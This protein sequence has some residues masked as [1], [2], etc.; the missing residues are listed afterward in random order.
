MLESDSHSTSNAAHP[1]SSLAV[2]S[3]AEPQADSSFVVGAVIVAVFVLGVVIAVVGWPLFVRILLWGIVLACGIAAGL[4]VILA[5]NSEVQNDLKTGYWITSAVFA[6]V[7]FG[8]W[9]MV[10]TGPPQSFKSTAVPPHPA[11]SPQGQRTFDYW[12]RFNAAV[13]RGISR[14]PRTSQEVIATCSQLAYEIDRLPA[15]NID[16]DAIRSGLALRTWL[17]ALASE[18]ER[19]NSPG[20]LVGAFIRGYQGDVFGPFLE[21]SATTTAL[22]Q[23]LRDVQ[24]QLVST[25]AILSSR[26]GAEFPRIQF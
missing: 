12:N 16:P 2:P 9:I 17:V 15:T 25:R 13:G 4:S 3:R 26:Y 23:S 10:P 7:A 24:N 20:A 8:V 14:Q 21:E 22:G 1:S 6:L 19:R 5:N 18:T 11:L